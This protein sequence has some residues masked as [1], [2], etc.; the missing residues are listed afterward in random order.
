MSEAHTEQAGKSE[1]SSAAALTTNVK[2]KRNIDLKSI[3]Y[4][5]DWNGAHVV[6]TAPFLFNGPR[7][8]IK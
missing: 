5:K 2:R 4:S 3:V 8:R 1:G 7:I 6:L